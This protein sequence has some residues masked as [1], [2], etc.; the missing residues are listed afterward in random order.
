MAKAGLVETRPQA[1]A[2]QSRL[3]L[4]QEHIRSN[5]V[6]RQY[7]ALR[8]FSGSRYGHLSDLQRWPGC[9]GCVLY[10]YRCDAGRAYRQTAGAAPL[11][12]ATASLSGSY[13][14][15]LVGVAFQSNSTFYYS[16]AGTA[17]GDGR[18]NLSATGR[19]ER[20][21]QHSYHDSPE[22]LLG[23]GRLHRYRQR[24]EPERHR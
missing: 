18:G 19:G 9:R 7:D 2:A 5:R 24:Q 22:A 14:Y 16:Q 3:P 15:L 13:A 17:V 4:L 20:Q 6:A 10:V 12:C 8:Q 1:S 23:R 11:Q 21:W